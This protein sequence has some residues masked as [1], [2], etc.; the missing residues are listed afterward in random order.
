M[1]GDGGFQHISS[2]LPR[3]EYRNSDRGPSLPASKQPSHFSKGSQRETPK[4][5][6]HSSHRRHQEDARYHPNPGKYEEEIEEGRPAPRGKGRNYAPESH[7][8]HGRTRMER[9]INVAE[10]DEEAQRIARKTQNEVLKNMKARIQP[11]DRSRSFTAR[12]RLYV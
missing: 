6:T 9:E 5:Q 7:T 8:Q 2:S 4:T 1:R 12:P 10:Q 11:T 3:R